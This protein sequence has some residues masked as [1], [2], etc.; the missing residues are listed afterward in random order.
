MLK[1]DLSLK[2]LESADKMSFEQNDFTVDRL[3]FYSLDGQTSAFA[4]HVFGKQFGLGEN[5]A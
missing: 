1:S 2:L 5:Y 3:H 4:W